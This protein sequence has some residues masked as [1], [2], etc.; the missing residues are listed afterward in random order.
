MEISL[1]RRQSVM[2]VDGVGKPVSLVGLNP[3]IEI[4]HWDT[5]R[6]T[7]VM[8]YARGQTEEVLERDLESETIENRRRADNNLPP[9]EEALYKTVIIPRRNSILS[10]FDYQPYYDV[11]LATPERPPV[12]PLTAEQEL[13]I[14]RQQQDRTADSGE[15]FGPV[16]PKTMLQLTQ[17]TRAELRAWFD[18]NFTT[19]AQFRRLVRWV[20]IYLIRRF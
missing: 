19:E 3:A 17:M 16:E 11:W 7:G 8:Q 4:I 1:F 15:T 13:A 9:L 18:I 12:Q 5:V 2:V 20:F 10:S 6:N 14:T